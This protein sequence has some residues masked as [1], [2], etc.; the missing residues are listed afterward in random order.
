MT[1]KISSNSIL[2]KRNFWRIYTSPSLIMAQTSIQSKSKCTKS[3]AQNSLNSPLFMVKTYSKQP[4]LGPCSSPMRLTLLVS[5]TTPKRCSKPMRRRKDL[6]AGYLIWNQPP[7]SQ[8]WRIAKTAISV[9]N[10]IPHTTAVLSVA[11]M[12]IHKSSLILLILVWHWLNYLMRLAML[13]NLS[14]KHA[15]RTRRT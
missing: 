15:L 13:T 12:I 8:W 6:R 3:W 5:K 2:H 9:A 11:S 10:S 4:M 7:I 1:K 14:P